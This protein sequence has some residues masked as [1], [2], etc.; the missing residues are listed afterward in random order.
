MCIDIKDIDKTDNTNGLIQLV[1]NKKENYFSQVLKINTYINYWRSFCFNITVYS[2]AKSI[3]WIERQINWMQPTDW[4]LNLE[5]SWITIEYYHNFQIWLRFD[6]NSIVEYRINWT[7]L[8]ATDR[9]K[10]DCRTQSNYKRILP[11]FPDLITVRLKYCWI[12]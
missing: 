5:H 12:Q 3:E 6:W 4:N 11:R 8:N 7:Q 9:L 10:F 2:Q 1:T